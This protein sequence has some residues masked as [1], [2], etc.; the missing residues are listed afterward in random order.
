MMRRKLTKSLLSVTQKS[1]TGITTTNLNVLTSS[2]HLNPGS[3]TML[4]QE[5]TMGEYDQLR[6]VLLNISEQLVQIQQRKSS[7]DLDTL[8][9]I[10]D[11]K[12]ALAE[13]YNSIGYT[14]GIDTLMKEAEGESVLE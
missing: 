13:L 11:T 6:M 8:K 7:L 4:G 3:T 14:I 5:T 2:G 12:G 10:A 1:A 9:S